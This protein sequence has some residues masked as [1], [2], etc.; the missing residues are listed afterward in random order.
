MSYKITVVML[1]Q[2]YNFAKSHKLYIRRLICRYIWQRGLSTK[3]IQSYP[4]S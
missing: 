4:P 1:R 3:H 2:T